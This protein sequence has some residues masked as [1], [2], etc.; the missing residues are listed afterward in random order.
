MIELNVKIHELLVPTKVG[1][2]CTRCVY[3]MKM[4]KDNSDT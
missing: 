4:I 1:A 2:W 3:C